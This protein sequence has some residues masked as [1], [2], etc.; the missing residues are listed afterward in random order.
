VIP[1]A[2]LAL[3]ELA[4][5]FRKRAAH[6]AVMRAPQPAENDETDE[7]EIEDVA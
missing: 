2:S 5:G 7:T 1:F 6:P 3:V 4:R